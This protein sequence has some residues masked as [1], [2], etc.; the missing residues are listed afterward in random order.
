MFNS[1]AILKI[2]QEIDNILLQ[3]TFNN[4]GLGIK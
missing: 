4:W 2:N 3:N 1:Y